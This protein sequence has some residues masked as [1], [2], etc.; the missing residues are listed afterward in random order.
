MPCSIRDDKV[1][2]ASIL[3]RCRL[4]GVQARH[5]LVS[6]AIAG[7]FWLIHKLVFTASRTPSSPEAQLPTR[8]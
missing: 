3:H 6:A 5:A 1:F 8:F 4:E 2:A 7:C